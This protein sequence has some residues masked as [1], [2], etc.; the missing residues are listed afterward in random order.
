M[1]LNPSQDKT[2]I[3]IRTI[4]IDSPENNGTKPRYFFLHFTNNININCRTYNRYR[5]GNRISKCIHLIL[6]SIHYTISTAIVIINDLYHACHYIWYPAHCHVYIDI[7]YSSRGICHLNINNGHRGAV[8]P[9][10]TI[11]TKR[12]QLITICQIEIWLRFPPR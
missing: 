12:W 1:G 6:F 9:Q 8:V 7:H 11:V 2:L 5:R 10:M 3:Y 4:W